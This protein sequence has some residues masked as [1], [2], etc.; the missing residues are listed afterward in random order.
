MAANA[1]PH[2]SWGEAISAAGPAV[3]SVRPRVTSGSMG[4]VTWRSADETRAVSLRQRL[5]PRSTSPKSNGQVVWTV[6][7]EIGEHVE[8][9]ASFTDPLQPPADRLALFLSVVRQWLVDGISPDEIRKLARQ[10]GGEVI[11]E[12]EPLRTAPTNWPTP[13]SS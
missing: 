8:L 10:H 2:G 3:A 12:G 1:R 6:W 7:S 5:L 13:S 9:V 11:H 4:T